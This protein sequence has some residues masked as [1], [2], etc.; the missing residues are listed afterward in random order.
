M[1]SMVKS[2][3]LLQTVSCVPWWMHAILLGLLMIRGRIMGRKTGFCA[4]RNSGVTPSLKP[5]VQRLG[6][7]THGCSL[8]KHVLSDSCASSYGP[9]RHQMLPPHLARS[10]VSPSHELPLVGTATPHCSQFPV[11]SAVETRLSLLGFFF[12]FLLLI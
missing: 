12:I 5:G 11:D 6:T 4:D 2:Q 10:L 3:S 7:V 9:C 8:L 1:R